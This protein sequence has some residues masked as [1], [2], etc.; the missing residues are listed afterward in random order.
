[1]NYRKVAGALVFIVLGVVFIS[2]LWKK[3]LLLTCILVV[4][5]YFKH[6]F[7][8]ARKDLV[9]FLVI[10]FLGPAAESIIIW[11]G[12]SPWSYAEPHF[13]NFPIW[14]PAMWGLAGVTFASIYE[15]MLSEK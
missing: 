8:P 6:I 15:G 3:A 7:V 12:S 1:M 10:S 2:L 9:W 4:L 13:L 11:F 14:M 5:C